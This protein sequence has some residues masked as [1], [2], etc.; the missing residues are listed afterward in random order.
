VDTLETDVMVSYLDNNASL[1]RYDKTLPI[2]LA[3]VGNGYF[4]LSNALLNTSSS[5]S[6]FDLVFNK[7]SSIDTIDMAIANSITPIEAWNKNYHYQSI[8][9]NKENLR[10]ANDN[11]QP[12]DEW[13][14]G[15][16]ATTSN[17]LVDVYFNAKESKKISLIVFDYLGKILRSEVL[18]V[19]KG[20]SKYRFS[21]KGFSG[22]KASGIYFLKAVGFENGSVKTIYL[23]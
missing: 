9:I 8:T 19:Q 5:Y 16:T 14:V 21:T 20:S 4:I 18:Q 3:T 22:K 2:T 23:P 15:N 13:H 17:G 7:T 12:I 10:L 11:T 1:Y 6:A